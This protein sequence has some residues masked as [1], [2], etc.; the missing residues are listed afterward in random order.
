[1]E[2]NFY[3]ILGVSQ[4]TSC[5]EIELLYSESADTLKGEAAEAY[6][7][8][9]DINSRMAYDKWLNAEEQVRYDYVTGEFVKAPTEQELADKEKSYNLFFMNKNV[10]AR[11]LHNE[12]QYDLEQVFNDPENQERLNYADKVAYYKELRE[13]RE[14]QAHLAR[15][16]KDIMAEEEEIVDLPAIIVEDAISE[17]E[18]EALQ[19]VVIEEKQPKRKI[20]TLKGKI[21]GGVAVLA[22][23]IAIAAAA[24]SCGN[25]NTNVNPTPT[26]TTTE[27][28]AE[29]TVTPSEEPEEPTITPEV[30]PTP[31]VPEEVTE[32]NSEN[33]DVVVN[34]V[35]EQNKAKGLEV[36]A[37][38]VK[39]A[40]VFA[41]LGAIDAEDLKEMTNGINSEDAYNKANNYFVAVQSHNIQNAMMGKDMNKYVALSDICYN[42]SD[43]HILQSLDAYSVWLIECNNRDILTSEDYQSSFKNVMNF[44][45][46]IG[47]GLEVGEFR[48]PY[49]DLSAGGKFVAE[50]MSP[51]FTVPYTLSKHATQENR[52]VIY[53]LE[54][55]IV[56][57]VEYL[58][59]M[60]DIYEGQ[61]VYT[62]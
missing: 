39:A 20:N 29:P 3:E 19:P 49:S 41:N 46:E 51:N 1:M 21:I 15:D 33:I 62:K 5:A 52:D 2:K 11:V 26:P 44:Y 12:R 4:D 10:I 48:Y 27:Q 58:N 50:M 38:D 16:I 23:V 60:F 28:P 17:E 45:F 35:V 31:I 61:K 8:L 18:R 24:R 47:K 43:K 59:E 55:R 30:T 36:N 13:T 54:N 37:E 6:S 56:D 7:V 34:Y 25:G 53:S 57:G 42:E 40:L 14:L 9:T 32:L 22:A